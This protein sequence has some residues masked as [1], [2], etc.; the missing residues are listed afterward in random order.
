MIPHVRAQK[1][2]NNHASEEILAQ[3]HSLVERG[4]KAP[5]IFRITE[6]AIRG[7]N[8]TIT[9]L[10]STAFWSSVCQYWLV[11]GLGTTYHQRQLIRAQFIGLSAIRY[12][13]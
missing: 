8:H 6:K 7:I 3:H 4:L 10:M 9:E 1:V 2:S 13:F 5:A 11:S 12:C